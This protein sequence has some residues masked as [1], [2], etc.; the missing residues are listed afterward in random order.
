MFLALR[1]L[2]VIALAFSVPSLAWSEDPA[3]P[4]VQGQ[5]Q[6]IGMERDGKALDESNFKGST[7]RFTDNKVVG[8]N[9]DGSEF[10]SA[11]YTLNAVRQPTTITLVLTSGS[12]KGK[13]LQGLIERKDDTIR[14]ILAN[15]GT[16]RPTEFKTKQNQT[17][18][19]LRAEK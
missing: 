18:Y 1:T 9:K 5:H 4:K 13:E 14:V 16:D 15:P 17:L 2:V 10:M 11:D 7:V 6:I 19:T 3:P 12:N 8:A